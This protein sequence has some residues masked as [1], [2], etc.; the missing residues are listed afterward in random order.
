MSCK[1][2]EGKNMWI[3]YDRDIVKEVVHIFKLC[4]IQKK[5]LEMD[6]PHLSYLAS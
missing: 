4:S 6:Q 2:R 5:V 1:N 3:K